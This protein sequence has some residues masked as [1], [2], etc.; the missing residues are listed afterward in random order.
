MILVLGGTREGREIVDLLLN[1]NYMVIASVTSNYGA[2]LLS[3]YNIRIN[4]EKLNQKQLS[5]LIQQK[6]INLIIDATH[7]FA[8]KISKNAIEAARKNNIKYIRYERKKVKIK[9]KYDHIIKR[10]SDYKEAAQKAKK[11]KKIFLT[12][13]S[14]NLS[15]FTEH[16][17]NWKKR[18]VVRILPVSKYLKKLEN[19]GFSPVNIIAVQGPFSQEFNQIIIKNYKIEV[20]VTKASGRKGGLDTK[21]KAAYSQNIP[22]ILLERPGLDYE[23]VVSNYKELLKLV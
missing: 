23:V 22:I 20:L 12:I 21:I 1:K 17:A 13:G 14:N 4:R 8:R 5:D 2:E 15:Y 7:P 3:K 9:P 11:Y 19:K 10:V 18:L 6:E 16:I